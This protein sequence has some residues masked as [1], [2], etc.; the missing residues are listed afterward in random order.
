MEEIG[1]VV[2]GV[3]IERDKLKIRRENEERNEEKRKIRREKKC[4][5]REGKANC[6]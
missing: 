1:R 6:N 3:E 4:G 2:G 5:T